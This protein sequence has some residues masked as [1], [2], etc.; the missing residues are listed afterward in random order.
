MAAKPTITD[1]SEAVTRASTV[2]E[3]F[4]PEFAAYFVIGRALAAAAPGLY[5]DARKLVS[6]ADPTEADKEELARKLHALANPET[7]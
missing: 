6:A 3:I 4:L 1:L 5:E 2:A 7:A